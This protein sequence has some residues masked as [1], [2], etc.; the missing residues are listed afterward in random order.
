MI[1]FRRIIFLRR[2]GV[3]VTAALADLHQ[4]LE[5]YYSD[6]GRPRPRHS[7]DRVTRGSASRCALP[8]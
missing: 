3:F 7:L 5:P 1:A 4:E 6:I 2:I 8:T